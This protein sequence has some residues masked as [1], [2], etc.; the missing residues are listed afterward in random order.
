VSGYTDP[1]SG[2]SV[3]VQMCHLDGPEP[4]VGATVTRGSRLGTVANDNTNSHIHMILYRG[5]TAKVGLPFA[6]DLA[7]DGY[8]LPAPALPTLPSAN[9][10]A[11]GYAPLLAFQCALYSTQS[12]PGAPPPSG[13]CGTDTPLTSGVP[14]TGQSVASQQ[15]KYYCFSLSSAAPSLTVSVTN[16]GGD[17]DLYVRQTTK[18]T[19]TLGA[20]CYSVNDANTTD[21]CSVANPSAGTWWVG[22]FGWS[23]A[24]FT[25][26]AT[27]GGSTMQVSSTSGWQ[28]APLS[29]QSGNLF[30]VSYN[31][32]TWTVDYHQFPYIGP[33]GY[34]SS[35]DSSIFQGCKVLSSV[36][37][38]ALLGK[39]GT[40]SAFV[41]GQGGTFTAGATGTLYLRINDADAC[42]GDNGGSINVTLS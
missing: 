24:T 33:A 36:P 42:L 12:D 16:V 1:G 10:Y 26:S 11:C 14:L 37:Y 30:R 18:P 38:G 28:T 17:P 5:A 39:I 6:G 27:V 7:I 2:Q 23:A 8:N 25:V 9:R 4:T 41:I 21:S 15:W 34:S 40:G 22:V 13:S 3:F 19:D 29:L 20:A 35:V 31:S 32:G